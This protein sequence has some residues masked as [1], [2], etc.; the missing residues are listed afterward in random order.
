MKKKIL[1]VV[2]FL[3]VLAPTAALFGGMGIGKPDTIPHCPPH[4]EI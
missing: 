4:K 3:G 2:L 1:S